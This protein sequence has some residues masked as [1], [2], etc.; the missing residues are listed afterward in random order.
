M[1]TIYTGQYSINGGING[2]GRC[3]AMVLELPPPEVLRD[4]SIR[5]DPVTFY[6][7]G[8]E[9]QRNRRQGQPY[10]KFYS[11]LLPLLTSF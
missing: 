9:G 11:S 3:N 6:N 5:L 10:H 8:E 4:T 1:L 2:M 7:R